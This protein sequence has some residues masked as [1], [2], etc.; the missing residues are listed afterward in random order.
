MAKKKIDV[1]ALWRVERLGG[2]SLSPDGA[3]AAVTVTRYSM[4]DNKAVASLWLLSTLGGTPRALT[5][6]GE[7]DGQAAFSPR[8]DAVGFVAKREQQGQKDDEP[9]LYLIAPDGGEA[10][11][12]A[13][14]ATGVE[15]FRW[16]PDGQ[17][18][19]FVSWVWPDAKG[20]AEQAR[21]LKAFKQRKETGYVTSESLYRYWDHT[22]PMG[23]APQLHVM[24]LASGRVRNVFEGS[25]YELERTEPG[26]TAFD[27]SPDGRRIVFAFDPGSE[28][29]IDARFALAELDLKS[30]RF[31]VIVRDANWSCTAP[32]YSPD[33]AQVAFLARHDGLKHTMPDQLAR[34][35]RAD[36]RWAVESAEW[37]HEVKA[38]LHW[39]DDGQALLFTAEQHGRTHLWR[40]DLPD[41]RAERLVEGGTVLA[42]DKCAGT[43]VTLADAADHPARATAHV[44]GA[45]PRRI[46][47]FNDKLLAG[48]DLGRHEEVWITGANG[49]RVQMWLFYPPGFD[50]RR[51]HPLL[52]L[53]HGGPH[54]ASGDGWHY[55]WNHNLFAAQGYVVAAVNY[56]GSSSFGYAFAD[57]ITHRW[58]ELELHDIEAATAWLLK[59]PWIDKRR[60]FASGGSYGGYMV[61]WMNGHVKAGRYAAYVCHAGCFDW[62]A[63]FADDAYAWFAKEHGAAYW[64]DMAKIHAQSPHAFAG[65]MATPTLVIHGALDYRVPDAQGLAYYNTLK[66]RGVDARLLWF[67][68]E[69]HWVLKPRNSRL[70]YAEFFGWLERHDAARK[71]PPANP[72]RPAA[73]RRRGVRSR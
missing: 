45:A 34:W 50:A 32:R 41:R 72:S 37:D 8:G 67:P 46:E 11:R 5:Q 62:V 24:E 43:L 63:M 38:P 20:A 17:R 48:L 31:D 1:E 53:I 10:R 44:P 19:A 6:C 36:R 65:T 13:T 58:G 35:Q 25:G 18:I 49:D 73:P 14:V 54:T 4:D 64:D 51:K 68:D 55:R 2:V 16:F 29:R 26:A 33:G 9:Q 69:N 59:K 71:R 28:K 27:I 70:W 39:E 12:V 30:G 56:H 40:F 60:V 66:A 57:S 47:R 52:H 23:R 42:F 3:Q 61:A 15:G 21:R 22:L 7:K